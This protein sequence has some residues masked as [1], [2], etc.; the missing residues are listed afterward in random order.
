M[1]ASGNVFFLSLLIQTSFSEGKD[2]SRQ[3]GEG[4]EGAGRHMWGEHLCACGCVYVILEP[5]MSVNLYK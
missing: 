2:R 1:K 5:H 4:R 3:G